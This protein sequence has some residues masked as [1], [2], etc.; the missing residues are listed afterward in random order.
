MSSKRTRNMELRRERILDAA[1]KLIAK[2]GI[3]ALT[4]RG[5][6]SM[7]GVTVPTIYNLIGDRDHLIQALVSDGVERVWDR[8]DFD[9]AGHPVAMAEMIV[10]TAFD[11]IMAEADFQRALAIAS[12][13]IA[14][15]FAAGSDIGTGIVRAGDRSAEMAV[16]VCRVAEA[17]GVLQGHVSPESLGLQMYISWRG[18]FRDWA[19]G[20][21]SA[22]EM[23]RRQL[24]GFYLAMAADAAPEFR[25]ALLT[26][27]AALE[28]EKKKALAA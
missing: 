24:R 9:T 28:T 11:A 17:G 10:D 27:I 26:K 1:R 3:E 13:Q 15:C 8:L 16:E 19:Y 4:T 22:Q 6:A 2:G 20:A 5:L 18:P 12:D 21:I 23:R 25:Q 7:A 14:G